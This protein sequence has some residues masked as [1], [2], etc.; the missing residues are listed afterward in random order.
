MTMDEWREQLERIPDLWPG[1][2]PLSEGTMKAWFDELGRFTDRELFDALLSRLAM[3]A[4]RAP[5]LSSLSV[6]VRDAGGNRKRS[7]N[8]PES[9][10]DRARWN[11]YAKDWT[12]IH[13]CMYDEG[14]KGMFWEMM[15]SEVDPG[16]MRLALLDEIRERK[17]QPMTPAQVQAGV[18]PARGDLVPVGDVLEGKV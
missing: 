5:G 6:A 11:L 3:S 7:V 18:A 17:I 14:V 4:E 2:K 8:E 9:P 16:D 13:S 1:R 12:F 15:R 10:E